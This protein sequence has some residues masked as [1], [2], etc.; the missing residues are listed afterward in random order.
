[1]VPVASSGSIRFGDWT[2]NIRQTVDLWG[3]AASF[4][5]KM[6]RRGVT[7]ALHLLLKYDPESEKSLDCENN[8][9]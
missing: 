6:R 1:M 7:Q 8:F 5:N 2:F 9:V 3:H 4:A